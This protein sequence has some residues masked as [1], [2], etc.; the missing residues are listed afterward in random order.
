MERVLNQ[1]EID[2]MVRLARGPEASNEAKVEKSVIP[3]TFR[4]NGQLASD[5][6]RTITSLHETFARNLAQSLG[7]YLSVP[8]ETKLVSVEQLTYGEFF[9]RVP[10]LTYMVALHTPGVNTAS[11]MQIDHSVLAP[12]IDILLG[13][14]GDCPAMTR[15]VTEVEES[16]TEGL[17]K[18]ICRE[19]NTTWSPFATT[20][21]VERRQPCAQ[22]QTFLSASER[23]LCLSLEIKLAQAEGNLNLVFPSA[24]S[25]ELLRKLKSF[26]SSSTHRSRH[27]SSKLRER[28]L[29]CP[30]PITHSLRDI[31]L[32]LEQISDLTIGS[33]FDLGIPVHQLATLEIGGRVAFDAMAV[34]HGNQRAA[35]VV[36]SPDYIR[37]QERR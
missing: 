37:E 23:T 16:I 9:E 32:S 22:M 15:E 2:A 24:I 26:T 8:F 1:E 13:G 30:F 25:S 5:Q 3:C 29:E 21:E 14:A 31:E 12:A 6:I 36:A 18:V 19:L 33:V 7:A 28:M 4:S 20:F 27:V 17:A 11:A 10:E 34:R 35:Q